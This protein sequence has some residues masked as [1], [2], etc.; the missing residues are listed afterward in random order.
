MF[1]SFEKSYSPREVRSPDWN[2]SLILRCLSRPPF[3]L[4]KLALDKHLPWKTSFLLALELVKRVSELNSLSFR[5]RHSLGWRSCTFSFLL[6]FV[7]ETKNPYLPD[8]R[9][10]EFTIPSLDDFC[11]QQ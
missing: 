6:D 7:A 1:Y 11:G 5:V 2:L 3:E 4:L 8:S 9:F 10:D